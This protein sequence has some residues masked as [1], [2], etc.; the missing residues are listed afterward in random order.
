[1]ISIC[2]ELQSKKS[3]PLYLY[4][5]DWVCESCFFYF[6]GQI[7]FAQMLLLFECCNSGGIRRWGHNF[8]GLHDTLRQLF[9]CFI[10]LCLFQLLCRTVESGI[11]NNKKIEL[12]ERNLFGIRIFFL[13]LCFSMATQQ[14]Y[15]NLR[16]AKHIFFVIL[17]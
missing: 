13:I 12:T 15:L 14:N 11:K 1:M 4:E 6:V 17:I 7:I 10:L 2:N 3:K 9:Y 8:I 16:F 5:N